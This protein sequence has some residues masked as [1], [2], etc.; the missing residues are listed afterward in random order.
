MRTMTERQGRQPLALS[1][2]GI[3]ISCIAFGRERDMAMDV[4]DPNQ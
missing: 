3:H 2:I 1:A 4:R